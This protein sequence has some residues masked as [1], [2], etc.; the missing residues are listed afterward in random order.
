MSSLS[1]TQQRKNIETIISRT[2]HDILFIHSLNETELFRELKVW[3]ERLKKMHLN[4][5]FRFKA[6]KNLSKSSF[7]DDQ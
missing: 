4:L 2:E 5:A 1:E 3:K 7:D 6:I